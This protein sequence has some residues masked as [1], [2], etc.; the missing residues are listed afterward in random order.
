MGKDAEDAAARGCRNRLGSR[1]AAGGDDEERAG[2]KDADPEVSC[3]R[4]K[5]D[6]RCIMPRVAGAFVTTRSRPR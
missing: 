4:S 5:P 3:G 6:H 1:A 2:E